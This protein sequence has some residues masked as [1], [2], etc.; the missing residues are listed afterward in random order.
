MITEALQWGNGYPETV[1]TVWGARAITN[2][3]GLIDLLFDRQSSQG[4]REERL[5]LA[6]LLN[7]F[8]AFDHLRGVYEKALSTGVVE[9]EI[10][11]LSH[12]TLRCEARLSP[13]FDYLYLS[14]WLTTDLSRFTLVQEAPKELDTNQLIWSSAHAPPGIGTVIRVT[15]ADRALTNPKDNCMEVL[16]YGVDYGY[17]FC[18]GQL[19]GNITDDQAL[20][21]QRQ[22][23]NGIWVPL[24]SWNVMGR[25]WETI[26][27][28]E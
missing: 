9:G 11:L 17:L 24:R 28:E 26:Q 21:D 27:Q 4:P 3:R 13:H 12:P 20:Q 1:R 10:V 18:F 19:M 2:R 15:N 22:R 6:R 16:G 7:E 5:M 25:E 14:V 8:G 23:D